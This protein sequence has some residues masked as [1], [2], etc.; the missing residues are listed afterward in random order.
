MHARELVELAALVAVHG[1]TLVRA[2][3]EVPPGS[4]EP[5]WI[6]S[7]SRLDRWGRT[8]KSLTGS[9]VGAPPARPRSESPLVRGMLEEVLT[10]EVLTRVWA[11]VTCAYD[12]HH[13]TDRLEPVARSVLCG[14]QEARHRVLTLLVQGPEIDAELAVKLNR[15]RRR[16]ERWTDMLVGYLLGL[17]D[18]AQFAADPERAR[19][20]A[21]DL[22]WQH[23][24]P[25]GRH[26]W[27]LI[28]ASLRAAF[29]Q[30]L[31]PV[32]P[33]ADLNARIASGVLGCFPPELFDSTGIFRSAWLV[34]I[35][36]VTR[37][38]EGMID[39]L[40]AMDRSRGV[41]QEGLLLK[42]ASDRLRGLGGA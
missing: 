42:R 1:P 21:E 15:L 29:S 34:R 2:G 23:Q 35:S 41:W 24:Q 19:E 25:G 17:D 30:G 22:S 27:S 20:F 5:Y 4:I 32:S 11:A 39:E 26:A 28:E 37:D 6:A 12:R 8:L 38:C 7:K 10:G 13:G 16:T 33:N 3:R 36:S 40:L 9:P 31:A 18:L 14:H